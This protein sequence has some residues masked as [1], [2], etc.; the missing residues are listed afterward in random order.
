MAHK[1]GSGSTKNNRDSNSK[2]LGLKVGN[3][4]YVSAGSILLRQR[5]F[6]VKCGLNVGIGKD[7]TI[8]SKISGVVIITKGIISIS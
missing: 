5:G 3:L 4:Q 7:F 2:R 1:V 8:Y 6:K